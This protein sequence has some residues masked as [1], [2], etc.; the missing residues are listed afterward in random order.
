MTNSNLK[1]QLQTLYTITTQVECL[2]RWMQE[3]AVCPCMPLRGLDDALK[4]P[5][6][7]FDNPPRERTSLQ[8]ESL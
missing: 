6:F 4:F 7:I 3:K 8:V 5:S 2:A 1:Q